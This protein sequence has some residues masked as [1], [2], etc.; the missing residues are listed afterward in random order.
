MSFTNC[1]GDLFVTELPE[2]CRGRWESFI[3]ETLTE[4]NRKNTVDLV[5]TVL[6]PSAYFRCVCCLLACVLYENSRFGVTLSVIFSLIPH[7]EYIGARA[8]VG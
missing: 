8:G 2:D 4:T 5:R 6:T 1:G 3:E 7:A